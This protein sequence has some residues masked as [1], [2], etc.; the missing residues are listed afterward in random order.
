M[1]IKMLKKIIILVLVLSFLPIASAFSEGQ[2]LTQQQVNNFPIE[3]YDTINS[4]VDLL[5]CQRYDGF[6]FLWKNEWYYVKP[7]DCFQLD[8]LR[9]GTYIIHRETYF[10]RFSI[11]DWFYCV[12][13]IDNRIPLAD[14]QD[15][16]N[17]QMTDRL[18]EF[19]KNKI[20]KIKAEIESYQDEL[21]YGRD[22][23]GTFGGDLF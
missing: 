23:G 14:R 20:W 13:V 17:D 7:F 4:L 9:D 21:D 11:A 12:D 19:G 8:K 22:F 15:Y 5:E 1:F 16:C 3:N 2:T 10:A 6:N 18:R